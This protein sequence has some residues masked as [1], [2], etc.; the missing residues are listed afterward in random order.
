MSAPSRIPDL[1]RRLWEE[2]ALKAELVT[3]GVAITQAALDLAQPGVVAQ[4]QVHNLFEMDFDVHDF[5]LPSGFDLPLG[6]SVGFRW[7][8]RSA[9]V[10]TAD[11]ERTI[12]VRD[13]RELG[14]V[15]FHRRPGFYGL[16]TSDG[17]TMGNVAALYRHR[18]LFVAYSNECSYKD[19]GEDCA[20]CNIN[21]TKDVYGEKKGIFWKTPKQIGEVAAAAFAEDAIDHVTISGGVIPERRELEYY[22]DVA[23]A[24][25]AHTGRQDFNGTAVV[26]AP[27]DLRHI[28]RFKEA[29]YRTTAM[30]IEIWDSGYYDTICP[31]KARGG[32]GWEHWVKALKHA[33][34]VFG[35]GNVRS[36]MVAGLEP[37]RKTLEGLEYLAAHG[38]VGT[39]SVWCP[40]PGSELEGHRAPQPGWY[41]DLAEKTTAIWKKAGFT[42]QQVCDCNASNDTLQHDIWRIQD[43]LLPVFAEAREPEAAHAA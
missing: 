25:Q 40:N 39:F 10:I 41:L 7:N 13:G 11:G 6:L 15:K 30:N 19:R 28:D 9:N 5:E 37:K 34:Q 14:E 1:K 3:D 36:N 29:G 22:L 43:E 23:E 35:H 4:E 8:Q 33:G 21:H 42:F 38:V 17:Q 32:G 16:T 18:A 26:A 20:F 2:L 24:I 31:G 12:L 27:L